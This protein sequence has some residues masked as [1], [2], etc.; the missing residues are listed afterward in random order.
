AAVATTR[1]SAPPPRA[2]LRQYDV[3]SALDTDVLR[4]REGDVLTVSGRVTGV[5]RGL[6]RFGKPYAFV[7]FGSYQAGC[8]NLV[9]W[10]Q[11]L[12]LFER[13]GHDLESYRGRW[14]SVTGLLMVYRPRDGAGRG[15]PQIAV[16]LP[17]EIQLIDEREAA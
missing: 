12:E 11:A 14:A 10:S 9:L 8:F 4:D 7:N 2:V 3:L 6:T 16:S 13:G 17:S 5:R 1:P 15:R